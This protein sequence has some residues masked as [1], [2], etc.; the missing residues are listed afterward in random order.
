M[1]M[2][3]DYFHIWHLH[4]AEYM[5]YVGHK[6]KCLSEIDTFMDSD[7]FNCYWD[8]GYTCIGFYSRPVANI[9]E[10]IFE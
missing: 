3:L 5:V 7:C 1:L 4:D 8:S 2:H 10:K 6:N 9:P